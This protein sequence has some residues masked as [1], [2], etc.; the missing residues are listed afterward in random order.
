MK[1]L[2]SM[3]FEEL[4]L[5]KPLQRGKPIT[6]LPKKG[7]KIYA[8]EEMCRDI[9]ENIRNFNG[10]GTVA[11]NEVGDWSIYI[12]KSPQINKWKS[13]DGVFTPGGDPLYVCPVC[14]GDRH[15]FGI[16]N[17]ENEHFTCKE[18]GAYNRY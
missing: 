3:I 2:D 17:V 16:E 13:V 11:Q 6:I 12:A 1:R 14:G 5:S 8:T 18:C 9:L 4:P 15:L 7:V 10:D